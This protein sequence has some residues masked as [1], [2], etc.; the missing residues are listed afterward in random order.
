M[1]CSF[2]HLHKKVSGLVGRLDLFVLWCAAASFSIVLYSFVAP[3]W[4]EPGWIVLRCRELTSFSLIKCCIIKK[5]QKKFIFFKTIKQRSILAR[6]NESTYAT[7]LPQRERERERERERDGGL[8]E[9]CVTIRS[10]FVPICAV[11]FPFLIF[12]S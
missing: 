7:Q 3:A 8:W 5:K 11:I 4:T 10:V 2:F 9:V 12:I 6:H 1:L